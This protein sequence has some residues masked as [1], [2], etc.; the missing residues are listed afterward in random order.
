MEINK[1]GGAR[2]GSGRKKENTTNYFTTLPTDQLELFL[3]HHK[4]I[5]LNKA[6]RKFIETEN[7][8]INN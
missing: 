6:L 8:K 7:A 4:K 2:L 5:E 3:Q 1:K